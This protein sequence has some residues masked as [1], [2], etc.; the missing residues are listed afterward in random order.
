MNEEGVEILDIPII[1]DH[2]HPFLP[3]KETKKFEE[4]LTLSTLDVTIEDIRNT[5]LYQRIIVELA[6]VLG[7][8]PSEAVDKRNQ[9]YKNKPKE[10]IDKLFA[11]A[12]IKV[13]LLDTGYPSEEFT[14]YSVSLDYFKGIVPCDLKTIFRID[15]LIIRLLHQVNS[16]STFID[17]YFKEVKKAIREEG[18]IAIKTVVAYTTGL[19]FIKVSD[20]IAEKAFNQLKSKITM[21]E[22]A[23][24]IFLASHKAAKTLMDYLM[25][26]T[27]SLCGRENI[28]IQIHVGVGDSPILDLRKANPILLYDFIKDEDVKNTK[29][30]LVHA[31]YPYIEETGYLANNYPNVYLDLSEMTPFISYGIKDKLLRILEMCPTSKV[32]YGSDG[33]NIP[34]LFWYAAIETR[35]ALNEIINHFI[36]RKLI[37]EKWAVNVARQILF[38]NSKKV[39]NLD[40]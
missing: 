5:F 12:N 11:D 33:Y 27:A 21:G 36:N 26:K 38:E 16:F 3:E 24:N 30:I 29:I 14:G 31:G 23:V 39:Y 6:R 20:D 15:N 9:F 32:L 19:E 1:D 40:I 37:E 17:N 28:P 35:R 18:A 8:K 34:E 22:K 4:Y 2:C 10:Y 7:C 25:F 13:L